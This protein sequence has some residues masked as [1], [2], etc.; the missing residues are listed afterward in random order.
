MGNGE[1]KPKE[2]PMVRGYA[3]RPGEWK[4]WK[5]GFEIRDELL[6]HPKWRDGKFFPF[7]RMRNEL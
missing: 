7:I 6:D 4:P 3:R 5:V 1:S 2:K